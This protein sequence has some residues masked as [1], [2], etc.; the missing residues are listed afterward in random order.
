MFFGPTILGSCIPRSQSAA[1]EAAN[2]ARRTANNEGV[3]IPV[4]F[5]SAFVSGPTVFWVG[6]EGLMPPTPENPS[7]GGSGR[8]PRPR[9]RC[10]DFSGGCNIM[11][12][13]EMSSTN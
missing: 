3:P 1:A 8:S 2:R 9:V 11:H 4:V 5:G 12:P 10:S 13:G 7:G 6:H